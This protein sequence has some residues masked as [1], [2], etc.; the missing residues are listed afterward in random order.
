MNSRMRIVGMLSSMVV[1]ALPFTLSGCLDTNTPPTGVASTAPTSTPVETTPSSVPS[2]QTASPKPTAS[3][4]A[5]TQAKAELYWLKTDPQDKLNL[6]PAPVALDGTGGS[7]EAQLTAALDRLLKGPA[8]SDVSSAIPADT[9][10]KSVTVKPDGVHVDLSKAFTD[11]GGS[12]S[13]QGRLG[14][15]IYT[16]SSL[17]PDQPVWISVEGEPLKVLGGEGLEVSQPMTRQE[18]TK[19]FPL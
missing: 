15:V 12:T 2:T 18:F 17:N 5:A 7:E 19:N 4:P 8:N 10:L 9:K 3:T 1:A 13:M 6:S 16:A 11:G 14:Q